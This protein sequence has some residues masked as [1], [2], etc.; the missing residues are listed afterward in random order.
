LDSDK[1]KRQFAGEVQ[2]LERPV[3]GLAALPHVLKTP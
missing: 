2:L 1:A 3:A